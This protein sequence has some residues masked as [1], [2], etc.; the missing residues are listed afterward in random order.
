MVEYAVQ[1]HPDPA[2]MRLSDQIREQSV[3]GFE[4]GR[5]CHARLVTLRF[6]VVN[7]PSGQDLAVVVHYFA[8]VRVNVVV[9]LG[10]VF[11]IGWRN[12][13]R[14]EI[15]DL[16][17]EVFEIIELVHDPLQI[18]AVVLP[19]VIGRGRTVPVLDLQHLAAV[20]S[21]LAGQHIVVRVTVAKTV[22]EDLIHHCA[23][24]PVGDL[25]FR[26]IIPPALCA[27]LLRRGRAVF[28]GCRIGS[29]TGLRLFV[30]P[31]DAGALVQKLFACP[32]QPD[33]ESIAHGGSVTYHFRR[34]ID[35]MCVFLLYTH[36]DLA[37]ICQQDALIRVS[38]CCA[39]ADADRVILPAVP[40]KRLYSL[41]F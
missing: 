23:V 26:G 22:R 36:G 5:V 10:I 29:V 34:E 1:D 14:I 8:K 41:D 11:V 28:R 40:S 17:A 19:G 15:D 37:Q 24:G 12:K 38:C 16:H 31:L 35:E 21:V 30:P 32:G 25:E 39:E 18:A 7:R 27:G 4:V 2:H 13:D 33:P 3:A 20:V 6:E 9:I